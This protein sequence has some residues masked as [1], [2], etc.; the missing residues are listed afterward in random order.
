MQQPAILVVGPPLT[1]KDHRAHLA[2]QDHGVD[3]GL[4]TL[5]RRTPSLP[6][7]I[8]GHSLLQHKHIQLL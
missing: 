7:E 5:I 1:L 3:K 6:W 8:R 2:E 4:L